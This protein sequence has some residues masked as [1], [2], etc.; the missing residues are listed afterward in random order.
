MKKS[1]NGVIAVLI[2][3]SLIFS[4]MGLTAFADDEVKE[5]GGRYTYIDSFS[6][7]I[8]HG[9][10]KTTV[11]TEITGKS[12]VTSVKIKME[13]QKLSDGS[14]STV[15]TWEQTFSGRT[16]SLEKSKVTNPLGTYRLK[17]TVTAY[18]GSNSESQTFYEY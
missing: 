18:S 17:S 12:S 3:F 11:K 2:V 5:S 16:G 13:L 10:I 6:G 15:E 8:N 9:I 1:F 7:S 14:Y 4:F